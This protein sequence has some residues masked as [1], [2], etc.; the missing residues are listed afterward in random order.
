MAVAWLPHLLL[1]WRA[2][3]A[4][5]REVTALP[6]ADFVPRLVTVVFVIVALAAIEDVLLGG[7]A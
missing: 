4:A 5:G 1:T 2:T 6:L 3:A 7:H